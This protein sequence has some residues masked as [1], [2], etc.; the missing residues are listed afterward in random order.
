MSSGSTTAAPSNGAPTSAPRSVVGGPTAGSGP[1]RRPPR[2]PLWVAKL[3]MAVSGIIWG[4]FV[5]VHTVGNLKAYTGAESFNHYAHWL[6]EVLYPFLPREGLLWGL[7]IVLLL[8]LV[9]HVGAAAHLWRRGRRARG[10]HR[11]RA[12][13]W[14]SFTARTMPVT[15]LVLLGFIVFHILDLTTGTSPAATGA[16]EAPTLEHSYAYENLVASFS[17]P[18]AGL[19]YAVTMVLLALHLL[20]GTMTAGTDLGIGGKT[21]RAALVWIG[22][23]AAGFVLLA[24]A[25]IP[26]AVLA[27]VLR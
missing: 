12:R 13:G 8:A 26:L 22:G 15:G 20:H 4:L 14:R 10:P 2:L 3:A 19:V 24:N 25:S 11:A 9:V 6:R 5:L 27:G 21:A 1:N 16:F 7:R 23:L 18:W 17:R